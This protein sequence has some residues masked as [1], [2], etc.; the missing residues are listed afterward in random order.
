[1]LCDLYYYTIYVN[2]CCIIVLKK[3]YNLQI[4]FKSQNKPLCSLPKK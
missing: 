2:D 1:M 3:N 4:M